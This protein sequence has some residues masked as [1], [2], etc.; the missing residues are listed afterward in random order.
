A[1]ERGA[2]HYDIILMDWR[3]PGLDG[4][5]TSR[6]IRESR[7]SDAPVII[8]VTAHGRELLA[9]RSEQEIASLGG[10]L[11]KPVTASMLQDA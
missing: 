5:E 10:Y 9:E 1:A 8:M 4:W 6:R 2:P 3:M 11:V 7:E